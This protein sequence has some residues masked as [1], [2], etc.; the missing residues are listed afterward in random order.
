MRYSIRSI[1]DSQ[2]SGSSWHEYI[3]H[4]VKKLMNVLESAP[5]NHLLQPT[6]RKR[7]AAE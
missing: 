1:Y 7:P 5:P 6:G 3:V 2:G 4:D